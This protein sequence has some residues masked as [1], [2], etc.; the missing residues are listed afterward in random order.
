MQLTQDATSVGN[1]DPLIGS[2]GSDFRDA[3][4]E[5]DSSVRLAKKLNEN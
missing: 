3:I 1:I 4:N 2:T 5:L